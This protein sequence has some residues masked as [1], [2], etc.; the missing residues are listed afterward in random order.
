MVSTVALP[1][2]RFLW[3]IVCGLF[4]SRLRSEANPLKYPVEFATVNAASFRRDAPIAPGCLV[5]GFG[6]DLAKSSEKA[7]S[8]PFPRE[9]VN[10]R[11]LVKGNAVPLLFVSPTQINYVLPSEIPLGTVRVEVMGDKRTIAK[12]TLLVW[13]VSPALFSRRGDGDGQGVVLNAD[14]SPNS[15]E[16]PARPGEVVHLFGTGAGQVLPPVQDGFPAGSNPLSRT[17]V[18]PELYV[19]GY[20]A[21]VLFSGLAPGLVA[22]WQIDAIVPPMIE[23]SLS[24]PV[25]AR[26]AGRA[27]NVV[28]L[29]VL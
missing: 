6:K 20:A 18:K 4:G 26:L 27:S 15:P 22:T 16:K 14:W 1:R 23:P 11:V 2:R 9:L 21:Q 13:E 8:I 17:L 12:G 24:V 29:V 10:T 19:G 7:H 3:V 25:R 28:T 5:S